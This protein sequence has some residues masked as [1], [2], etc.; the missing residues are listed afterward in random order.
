MGVDASK[1][2][3]IN[4]FKNLSFKKINE[5]WCCQIRAFFVLSPN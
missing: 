3:N 4:K 5:H 2:L 1:R